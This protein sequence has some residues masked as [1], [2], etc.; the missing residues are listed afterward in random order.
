MNKIDI[1][2]GIKNQLVT[3]CQSN[4]KKCYSEGETLASYNKT[5]RYILDYKLYDKCC[6]GTVETNVDS[7][8]KNMIDVKCLFN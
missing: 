3:V 2:T 8:E 1:D 4:V 6:A 7:K 5:I